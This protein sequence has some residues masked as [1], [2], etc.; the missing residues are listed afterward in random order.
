MIK[1]KVMGILNTTPDSFFDNG[2]YFD[3]QAA[4][5]K[6][7]QLFEEGADL[8]D[9]GGESSR[10]GAIPVPESEELRRVVPVIKELS[11][12]ISIPISVDTRKASVAAA[13]IEAGAS[14]LNDITGFSDPAMQ[15]LAVQYQLPLC[16]MHMQGSPETMQK[17]AHYPEGVTAH[18]LKWFT[19]RIETL[20]RVGVHEK[21]IYLDPGIG[22]GKTI[23]HNLEILDNLPRF[24]TLGFPLLL[25]V[26]RKSFLSKILNKSSSDLLAGTLAV[27]TTIVLKGV[28]IIRV[29]DVKEH[30]DL[31][32][33][34]DRIP[35]FKNSGG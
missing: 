1:T 4:V 20:L 34:F 16:V 5:A 25:G 11:K 33:F 30:R 10:P 15:Q 29:H 32:D 26:S 24:K 17:T 22:F 21:Q 6:G 31:V 28:E 23:A 7:V 8:I 35:R 2:R 3:P 19:E 18:L 14:F 9:V 12:K 13:A 27:N